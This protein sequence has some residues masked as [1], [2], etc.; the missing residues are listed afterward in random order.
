VGTHLIFVSVVRVGAAH[1]TAATIPLVIPSAG[2]GRATGSW[3]LAAIRRQC[4]ARKAIRAAACH[5]RDH[6][7][8]GVCSAQ[9]GS[10]LFREDIRRERR[11]CFGVSY[12]PGRFLRIDHRGKRFV[13][14]CSPGVRA[15]R[16]RATL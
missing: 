4:R 2:V 3:L 9:S 8:P 15:Q 11:A 14:C 12:C 5:G 10:P 1:P 13:W 7:I 16:G 6:A